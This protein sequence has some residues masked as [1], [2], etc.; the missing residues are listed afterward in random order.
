M[1]VHGPRDKQA[2]QPKPASILQGVH[3]RSHVLTQHQPDGYAR[4]PAVARTINQGAV[5]H[6]QRTRR[7]EEL[8]VC[9]ASPMFIDVNT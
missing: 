2:T 9:P 5:S 6:Q 4:L 8:G 3:A 7:S 1:D